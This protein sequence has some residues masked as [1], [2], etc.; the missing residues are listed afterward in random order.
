MELRKI[1]A[2][3]TDPHPYD[4]HEERHDVSTEDQAAKQ[5]HGIHAFRNRL[6]WRWS[7]ELPRPLR[8]G[9]VKVLHAFGAG[10][11][12]AGR[13]VFWDGRIITLKEIA[14]AACVD[15]KDA[16][17]YISAAIA[18]GVVS[19]SG[20]RKRGTTPVYAAVVTD[21]PDWA[22]AVEVLKASRPEPKRRAPRVW[23][24]PGKGDAPP[25]P[26]PD[27]KGDAPLS[28]KGGC[29]PEGKGDA[30]PT[31]QGFPSNYPK[32]SR[33]DGRQA[34]TGSGGARGGGSAA[35]RDEQPDRVLAAAV[36]E[37]IR[38]L[39]RRLSEMFEQD[40]PIPASI[41]DA[42]RQELARGLTARQVVSRVRRRYLEWGIERDIESGEGE[43]VHTP[44]GALVRLVGPGNCTS[45]RC[46]DGMD[47]DTSEECRSC[48]REREDRRPA[49]QEP[50]QG[51]FLAPV[52]SGPAVPTPAPRGRLV[53]RDCEN[54]LCPVSFP[55][56]PAP[57][58]AGLC[59]DCLAAEYEEAQR[60][61]AR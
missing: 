7:D 5:P 25:S 6:F 52:P 41:E 3:R 37:V 61:A 27:G 56:A 15:V 29:T 10:A 1:T 39:P 17:R 30:P 36:G 60:L 40:R 31:S 22:A 49:V 18:A 50:V 51:A 24:E 44:V 23:D 38:G 8:E 11:N 45:P 35:Q 53:A 14:R 12:E 46:D 4:P 13:M 2:R 34:T 16:R 47:L 55:A 26:L 32:N 20:E 59:P 9:F 58:P 42:I 43:G 19:V 28:E 21:T 48:E 57:A 33:G 54:T